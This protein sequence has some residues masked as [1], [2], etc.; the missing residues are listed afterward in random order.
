MSGDLSWWVQ[1][2]SR[3]PLLTPAEEISLATIIQT[4]QKHP[5]PSAVVVRRGQR[6]ANRMVTANLRLVIMIAKRHSRL[7]KPDELMDL[8]QAGNIGLHRG[9][10]RFDPTR[11]YKFSTYGYWWIRQGVARYL[12]E[13]S[14]TIRLP[15]TFS[16]RI[17]GA[18]RAT[19]LLVGTLGREPSLAELAEELGMSANDLSMAFSRSITCASLDAPVMDDGCSLGELIA[20]PQAGDHNDRLEAMAHEERLEGMRSALELLPGRQRQLLVDRWGLLTGAPQTIRGMAAAAGVKPARISQDIRRAEMALRHRIQIQAREPDV[21]ASLAIPW[22]TR[23]IQEI[24]GDQLG[25][26]GIGDP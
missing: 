17:T 12:E 22:P 9:V 15:S 20:D 2:I 7:T 11:G 14:R 18:G 8:I 24:T 19:Q 4:W 1:Q 6:A 5:D 10:L 3:H 25:L 13:L 26:P 21:L 23:P 16:Q